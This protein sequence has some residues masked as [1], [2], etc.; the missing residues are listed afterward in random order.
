MRESHQIGKSLIAV[1]GLKKKDRYNP[2]VNY[3]ILDSIAG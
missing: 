3:E 1:N 2:I